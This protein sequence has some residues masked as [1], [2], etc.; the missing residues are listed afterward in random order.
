VKKP[1]LVAFGLMVVINDEVFSLAILSLL[2]VAGLLFILKKRS[3]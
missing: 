3:E 2:G 1:L